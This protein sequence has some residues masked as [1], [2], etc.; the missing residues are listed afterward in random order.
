MSLLALASVIDGKVPYH[1]VDGNLDPDPL[2]TILNLARSDSQPIL[3]ITVMPGPQLMGA[4][5]ISAGI[6]S[7]LPHVRIVWGGYFPT[8]HAAVC[9]QSHYPDAI[10]RGHGEFVFPLLVEAWL[11]N[12]DPPTLPGLVIRDPDKGQ[13]IDGGVAPLPN[14]DALPDFPYHKIP[15]ERYIRRTFLGSR[16]FPHHSSYGCPF[17]CNFCAVVNMVQGR[18]K[19]QSAKRIATLVHHFVQQWQVNAVEFYDNNFFVDEDRVAEFSQRIRNLHIQWWGEARVDTLARFRDKTWHA[20]KES[21][22]R[23]VF[24]GAESGSSET[25]RRMNKGGTLRPEV[26]LDLVARMRAL[27]II[28]ELSFI[29]GNPPDP[30]E[31]AHQTML[32]IR[33]IKKVNPATEIV[34]YLYTPEPLPGDM[35]SSAESFGFQFPVHLH[36]WT[37]PHWLNITQRRSS[38]LPWISPSLHRT[39]RNFERVLHA[40]Y[41]TVTDPRVKRWRRFLL[42]VLSAWRYHLRIYKLPLELRLLY[43]FIPYQRPETSSF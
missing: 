27:D 18:W 23:M 25:L 24:M 40:Y 14:P 3:G 42:K 30:V 43:R 6:K 11:K 10:I 1:I 22:L 34:L 26:T 38:H 35:L 4:V 19:A 9:I 8:Q 28:P 36:D 33:K 17:M 16:T 21:G 39:I 13:I 32:F 37:T 29:L 31:D 12:Q 2:Q 7:F 5:S 15:V 41:P 20:M